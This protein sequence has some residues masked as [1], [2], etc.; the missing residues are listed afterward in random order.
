MVWHGADV[1]YPAYRTSLHHTQI[2]V[3]NID[4]S[5]YVL[6]G[7]P[8]DSQTRCVYDE[9]VYSGADTSDKYNHKGTYPE[10]G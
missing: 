4:T 8:A 6:P 1:A 2:D 5:T 10:V 3:M 7:H 9:T